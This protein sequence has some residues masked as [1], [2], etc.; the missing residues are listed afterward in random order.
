VAEESNLAMASA[1]SYLENINENNE[2][3]SC[4]VMKAQSSMASA[5]AYAKSMWRIWRNGCGIS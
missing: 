3:I 4:G 1:L 2:N 5:A